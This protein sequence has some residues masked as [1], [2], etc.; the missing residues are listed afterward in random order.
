MN[1]RQVAPWNG[2]P[3]MRVVCRTADRTET[4]NDSYF[5]IRRKCYLK[6][7]LLGA[8]ALIIATI[9]GLVVE[10]F[11]PS[12]RALIRYESLVTCTLTLES[13]RFV[14]TEPCA[15]RTRNVPAS[16]H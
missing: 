4:L 2:L 14:A 3:M 13:G 15:A 12:A 1:R 10:F 8:L 5:R 9:I 7:T 6:S 11:T 16:P